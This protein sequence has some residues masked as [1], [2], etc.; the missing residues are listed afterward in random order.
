MDAFNLPTYED[1]P[2]P[3]SVLIFILFLPF[4]IIGGLIRNLPPPPGLP[5][6]AELPELPGLTTR[7]IT[8]IDEGSTAPQTGMVPYQPLASYQNQEEWEIEWSEEGLPT[9]VTV[10]RNA[11]RA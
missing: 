11:R 4:Q 9:R 10:H 1:S 8:G 6:Q 5:G 7:Y 2:G 3:L